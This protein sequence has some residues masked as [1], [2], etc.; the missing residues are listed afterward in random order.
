MIKKTISYTDFDGNSVKEDLYFNISKAEAMKLEYTSDGRLTDFMSRVSKKASEGSLDAEEEEKI[1]KFI[2][3]F[4]LQA[5]GKK[6]EDGRRFIKSEQIRSEFSQSAA[7]DAF[8]D[9]LLGSEEY[10][11]TFFSSVVPNNKG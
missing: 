9:E 3:D 8:L 1:V 10:M 6:S 7:F 4:V 2:V 5:Y 11:K